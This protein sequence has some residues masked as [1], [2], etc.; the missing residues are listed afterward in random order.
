MLLMQELA[1]SCPKFIATQAPVDSTMNDFWIMV[2][3]Q[4]SEVIVILSNETERGKVG[5]G[6]SRVYNLPV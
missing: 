5:Q 3:E 4:G 6:P 2:F 1:P